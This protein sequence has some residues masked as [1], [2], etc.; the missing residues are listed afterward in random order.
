MTWASGAFF[1]TLLIP[2]FAPC[3]D[4][5]PSPLA[6]IMFPFVAINRHRHSSLLSLYISNDDLLTIHNR[7]LDE[8]L[9]KP[10]LVGVEIHLG[11][12]TDLMSRS[13]RYRPNGIN[14]LTTGRYRSLLVVQ[15]LSR[16][17]VTTLLVSSVRRRRGRE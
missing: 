6:A 16:C 15:Q 11:T 2:R 13:T 7:P 5:Y 3:F 12:T 8:I 10:I 17:C 1:F 9:I 14:Y 4:V